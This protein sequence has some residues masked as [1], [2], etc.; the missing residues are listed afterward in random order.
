ML[1]KRSAHSASPSLEDWRPGGLE[2]FEFGGLEAWKD[3]EVGNMEIRPQ[4]F[5]HGSTELPKWSSW[6]L[7]IEPRASKMG[8]G[9]SK[10][11]PSSPKFN[12]DG[13]LEILR[14][15]KRAKQTPGKRPGSAPG[16]QNGSQ[17]APGHP[18]SLPT[19]CQHGLKVGS[20][21]HP[22]WDPIPSA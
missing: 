2:A 6:A 12:Q 15:P 19:W 14:H 4:G 22:T 10:M 20:E 18:K 16:S 5:Q 13:G 8:P 3:L 11:G 9:A 7:K 1:F 21:T 17:E